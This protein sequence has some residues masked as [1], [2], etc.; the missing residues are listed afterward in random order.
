MP[1]LDFQN[2][3][4][5]EVLAAEMQSADKTVKMQKNGGT[6]FA[7]GVTV[8]FYAGVRLMVL[9]QVFL[10]FRYD[11][12]LIQLEGNPIYWNKSFSDIAP[13]DLR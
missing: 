13:R 12:I 11:E 4:S 7:V 3:T 6:H 10:Y 8:F 9:L 2:S 1:L 5:L